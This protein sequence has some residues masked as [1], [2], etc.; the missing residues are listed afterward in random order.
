MPASKFQVNF[1][2]GNLL[3]FM[4]ISTS[5]F[6]Q[7]KEEEYVCTPCGYDCDKIESKNPGSCPHCGMDL[8]KKSAIRFKNIKPSDICSYIQQHPQAVLLDVRTK[9]EFSGASDPDYGTLKNAINISVQELPQRIAELNAFKDREIIVYCSHNH[10]S[11]QASFFL[12]EHGFT[13][14]ANMEGGMS[15]LKDDQCKK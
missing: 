2:L 6:S 5:L 13:K 15:V 11:P 10:R 3:F 8:V 14:I 4:V 7:A 12:T 1:F 9:E